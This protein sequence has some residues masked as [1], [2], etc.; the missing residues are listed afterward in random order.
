MKRGYIHYSKL[1]DES[2]T[3]IGW[4]LGNNRLHEDEI[5]VTFDDCEFSFTLI[6]LGNKVVQLNMFDD[7][8]HKLTEESQLFTELS[9]I[10]D[11]TMDDITKIL[12]N[13]GFK[14]RNDE[15]A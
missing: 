15:I 4:K 13:C 8:F 1:P 7:C 10:K 3:K 14:C 5:G 12:D 9:K 6:N 2:F 11:P